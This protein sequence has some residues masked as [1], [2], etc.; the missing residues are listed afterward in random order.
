MAIRTLLD[1]IQTRTFTIVPKT[2]LPTTDLS[3]GRLD[4]KDGILYVYDGTRSKWLSVNRQT[5]VFGRSGI[6]GNQ[7]LS[8]MGGG[9]SSDSGYRPAN[10]A[11]I[12]SMSV[13]TSTSDD[14]SI[15]IRKN[16]V[17]TDIASLVVSST[18]NAG[19]IT[20]D[21]DISVGDYLQCYLEYTGVGSGVEDPVVIIELAWRT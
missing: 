16:D 8:Y 4:I 11:T 2:S 9:V 6:T 14:Y 17:L 21:V 18:N 13:K 19:E 5:V 10:S 7:H 3:D 12:V 15:N 20:T 1:W